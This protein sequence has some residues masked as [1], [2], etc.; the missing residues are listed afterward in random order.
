MQ[1]EILEDGCCS[2]RDLCA[3]WTS[4]VPISGQRRDPVSKRSNVSICVDEHA[5]RRGLRTDKSEFAQVSAVRK[6]ADAPAEQDRVDDQ[7]PRR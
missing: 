5:R 1:S 4:P 2:A 7:Q 3:S 6:E